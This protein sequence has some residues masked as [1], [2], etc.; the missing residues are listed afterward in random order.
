VR[1]SARMAGAV[2][3]IAVTALLGSGCGSSDDGGGKDDKSDSAQKAPS[4]EESEPA[5]DEGPGTLPG[6]WK[7]QGRQYVLTIAGD[8]VTLLREETN[9]TG[10]VVDSGEKTIVLKCPGGAGQDRTNGT[11]GQLKGKSMKVSWNGGATDTYAK[12][13]QAPDKLPTDP[14]DV[15]KLVPSG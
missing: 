4:Q 5:A 3:V 7:A 11:V 9:C 13:A 15:E 10:R 2:A 12:V 14:K 8:A 6:V 1:T